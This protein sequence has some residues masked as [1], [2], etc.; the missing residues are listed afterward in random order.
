M[1]CCVVGAR[2]NF[3]KMAP[4]VKALTAR[5][6]RPLLIH[7]GQHYDAQLS[8][9][10]FR[11]LALPAPDLDLGV[12]SGSHA[13][14]TGRVMVALEPVLQA[15]APALVVVAGDV[16]STLAAALAA[17]KLNIPV[18]HVEA[19]LRSF[20]RTMPE[21]LNRVLTDHLAALLFT[22]EASADANLAREGI[23]P[24]RIFFVGNCMID[25]L[26]GHLA[27]ALARAPWRQFGVE[28]GAFGVVT[29]H[30]PSNVDEAQDLAEILHA[31]AEVSDTLPLIFPVHPRTRA[32][33]ETAM[34]Q[35]HRIR[36]VEPLGYLDFLGLMAQARLVFTDSGGVQE[37]TTALGV[38]CLTLRENTERPITLIAGTNRLVGRDRQKIMQ[39]AFEALDHPPG[40]ASRPRLWDGHAG[41]RTAAVIQDW[42]A[43]RS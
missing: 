32:G 20:D 33:L 7:T 19:G 28:P 31:L 14:Q 38:A 1:I 12:G 27:A 43:I 39:A 11:E 8:E 4:V 10:F 35:R 6:C 18:A 13:N 26:D 2:P 29:L 9:I 30:R 40:P 21:E 16:N 24:E 5:G 25:S 23:A 36:T 15:H 22:T 42:V 17:A 41:E 37:E 34:P 3:I